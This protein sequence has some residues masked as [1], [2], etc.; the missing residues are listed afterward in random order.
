MK[1]F[2]FVAVASVLM[3]ASAGAQSL[4]DPKVFALSLAKNGIKVWDGTVPSMAGQ[5]AEVSR[6]SS[7]DYVKDCKPNNSGGLDFVTEKLSTGTRVAVTPISQ[8]QDVEELM[9]FVNHTSLNTMRTFTLAPNCTVS[10]PSTN[11]VTTSSRVKLKH[12][13]HIEFP[14]LVG[15]D[16]YVLTVRLL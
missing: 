6:T 13:E 7:Q 2:L 16:K 10:A 11:W 9:V 15:E 14:A 8:D 12:G 4:A 5:K 3:A 1:K